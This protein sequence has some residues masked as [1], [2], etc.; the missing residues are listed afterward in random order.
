MLEFST[1]SCRVLAFR[2]HRTRTPYLRIEWS[3]CKVDLGLEDTL[4]SFD[5][6]KQRSIVINRLRDAI[7]ATPLHTHREFRYLREALEDVTSPEQRN[8]IIQRIELAREKMPLEE[9]ARLFA[10]D[11]TD[12]YAGYPTIAEA[13][14]QL[15][16]SSPAFA[17]AVIMNIPHPLQ[18]VIIN[19]MALRESR[20]RDTQAA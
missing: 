3:G 12:P 4:I 10:R 15:N 20:K 19:Q 6:D 9:R 11:I 1:Y 8:V 18:N 13:S 16:D 7:H 2:G 14:A 17:A 5:D